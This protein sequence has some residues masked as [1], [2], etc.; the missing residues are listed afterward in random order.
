MFSS[1]KMPLNGAWQTVRCKQCWAFLTLMTYA[2]PL[3]S[4]YLN[5][6]KPQKSQT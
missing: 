1:E 3:E 5:Q 6:T 2:K 4:N